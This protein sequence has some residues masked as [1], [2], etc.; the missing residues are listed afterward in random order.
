M[1]FNE[2]LGNNKIKQDLQEIIDNNTISHSYMFVGIDGIGKKLIAKE[3]AR[4]ILCLNKQ[5]QKLC[6]M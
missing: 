2:I 5:N 1:N 6:N 4:K 3:F